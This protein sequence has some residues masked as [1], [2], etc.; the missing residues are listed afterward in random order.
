MPEPT[1]IIVLE[2]GEDGWTYRYAAQPDQVNERLHGYTFCCNR[3][4]VVPANSSYHITATLNLAGN[5]PRIDDCCERPFAVH[6]HKPVELPPYSG[7]HAA[8]R[9]CGSRA[10]E[11]QYKGPGVVAYWPGASAMTETMLAPNGYP[12]EWLARKCVVCRAEWDEATVPEPPEFRTETVTSEPN[13]A[14]YMTCPLRHPLAVRTTATI[15]DGENRGLH[16]EV[17][18]PQC[19]QDGTTGLIALRGADG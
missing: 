5:W 13:A 17:V 9:K 2:P 7:E 6:G 11:T 12:K 18:C 19:E 3:A 14:L 10:V 16:H 1:D 4:I 15:A 8:C